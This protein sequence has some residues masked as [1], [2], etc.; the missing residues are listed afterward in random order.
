MAETIPR[1]YNC[2]LIVEL[3]RRIGRSMTA[4]RPASIGSVGGKRERHAALS[5]SAFHA[6]PQLVPPPGAVIVPRSGRCVFEIAVP[7]LLHDTAVRAAHIGAAAAPRLGGSIGCIDYGGDGRH[8]GHHDHKLLHEH[9]LS[10][11]V[12]IPNAGAFTVIDLAEQRGQFATSS[13]I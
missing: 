6:G 10:L 5:S 11:A 4:L 3:T 1:L 2:F 12:T 7:S 9:P 13:A 8:H